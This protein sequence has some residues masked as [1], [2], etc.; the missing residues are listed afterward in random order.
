V[1]PGNI[2][3]DGERA[4]RRRSAVVEASIQRGRRT[5]VRARQEA[6]PAILGQLEALAE[7]MDQRMRVLSRAICNRSERSSGARAAWI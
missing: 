7:P 3:A 2:C 4:G 5:R 1:L 6:P